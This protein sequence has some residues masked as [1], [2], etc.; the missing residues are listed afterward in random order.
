MEAV[1]GRRRSFP[2]HLGALAAVV[3]AAFGGY[4]LLARGVDVPRAF[5]D[6]LLY[7]EVGASIADGDGATIRGPEG[8]TLQPG[9]QSTFDVEGTFNLHGVS[10]RIR[11]F[12][13]GRTRRRGPTTTRERSGVAF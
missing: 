3:V 7:F 8:V 10:R 11:I 2:W 1:A 5:S 12:G 13:A 9:K 6:E 4:A